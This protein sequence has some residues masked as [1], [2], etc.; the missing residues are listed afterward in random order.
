MTKASASEQCKEISDFKC[1]WRENTREWMLWESCFVTLSYVTQPDPN[2]RCSNQCLLLLKQKLF[3]VDGRIR[4]C[5]MLVSLQKSPKRLEY[6][7]LAKWSGI[8]Q[9]SIS[10]ARSHMDKRTYKKLDITVVSKID[11]PSGFQVRLHRKFHR[12]QIGK[13]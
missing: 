12:L 13:F 7:Q 3:L 4:A 1:I 10:K 5:K 2:S 9:R 8:E 6:H 11:R